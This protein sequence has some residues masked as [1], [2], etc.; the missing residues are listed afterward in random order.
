MCF[1]GGSRTTEEFVWMCFCGSSRKT[2]EFVWMCFCGRSRKT[3]EFVWMCFMWWQCPSRLMSLVSIYE[4]L[5][6][7][8]KVNV[9]LTPAFDF[10]EQALYDRGIRRVTFVVLNRVRN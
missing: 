9:N 6:V 7:S 3:E 10:Q 4:F 2:K 8:T 1:C 5:S